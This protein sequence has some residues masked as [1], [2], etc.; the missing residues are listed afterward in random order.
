VGIKFAHLPAGYITCRLLYSTFEKRIH[1]YSTYLF[2]GLFG[3]VAPDLDRFL[4]VMSDSS[5]ETLKHDY[6]THYPL[7]WLLLCMISYMWL[8]SSNNQN[9]VSAFMFSLGG[10][11]HTILDTVIGR[12]SW[13][14][15]FSQEKYGIV[16][17]V[18]HYDPSMLP[19]FWNF[20]YL[21]DFLIILWAFTLWSKSR[22]GKEGRGS[23]E[24]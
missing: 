16:S 2:W 14:A 22:K 15:P 5:D 6:F 9:P 24:L 12:I 21:L 4:Q 10:F 17:L 23:A 3:A 1:A 19:D 18:R 8:S 11:I 7:F 20:G 13:F